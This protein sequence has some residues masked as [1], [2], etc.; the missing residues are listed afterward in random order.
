MIY[1]NGHAY[2][3]GPTAEHIAGC[4]RYEWAELGRL[5][6]RL[7]EDQL[8]GRSWAAGFKVDLRRASGA[9]DGAWATLRF[10]ALLPLYVAAVRPRIRRGPPP[11]TLRSPVRGML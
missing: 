11:S 2:E 10:T 1:M 3:L 7:Y 6:K 9:L 8:A 5:L 4:M